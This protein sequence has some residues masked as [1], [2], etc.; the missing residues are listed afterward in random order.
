MKQSPLTKDCKPFLEVFKECALC[1]GQVA[2]VFVYL[3]GLLDV[4]VEKGDG[5]R[6]DGF[7]AEEDHFDLIGLS[8]EDLFDEKLER[9]LKIGPK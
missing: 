3:G 6:G 4:V 7:A 9:G 5:G 8:L 1:A 2:A